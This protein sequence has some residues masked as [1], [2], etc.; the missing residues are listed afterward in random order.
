MEVHDYLM[1][2]QNLLLQGKRAEPTSSLNLD[3]LSSAFLTCFL[4]L[5]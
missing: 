1:E 2:V 5:Y 4:T 3:W